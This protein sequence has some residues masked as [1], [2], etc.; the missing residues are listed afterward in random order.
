MKRCHALAWLSAPKIGPIFNVVTGAPESG[1]VPCRQA[2]M[3]TSQWPVAGYTARQVHQAK[4]EQKLQKI[5]E[6]VRSPMSLPGH[7]GSC[8]S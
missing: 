8:L 1:L 4:L 6:H 3:M 5:E 2:S 7:C